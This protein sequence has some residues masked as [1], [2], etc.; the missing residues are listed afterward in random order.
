MSPLVLHGDSASATAPMALIAAATLLATA[1]YPSSHWDH[2]T[3]LT[4][5]NFAPFVK[6]QV[7]EGKTLFVRWIAS[8]G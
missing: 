4:E 7:D 1:I 3:K 5:A 8:A 2:A 6:K